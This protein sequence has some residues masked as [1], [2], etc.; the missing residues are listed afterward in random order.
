M[1][2]IDATNTFGVWVDINLERDHQQDD[3]EF[4]LLDDN[5]TTYFDPSEEIEQNNQRRNEYTQFVFEFSP[6][7]IVDDDDTSSILYALQETQIHKNR[8][9]DDDDDDDAMSDISDSVADD[10][11]CSLEEALKITMEDALETERLMREYAT[12]TS[13]MQIDTDI[14]NGAPLI[15]SLPAR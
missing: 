3:E 5:I 13:F 8:L 4:D 12:R 2:F 14:T 11:F 10:S 7:F 9:Q 1:S 15:M 6:D